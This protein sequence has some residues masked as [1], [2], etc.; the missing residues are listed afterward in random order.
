MNPTQRV[1]LLVNSM[2]LRMIFPLSLHRAR[3]RGGSQRCSRNHGWVAVSRRRAA[4]MNVAIERVPQTCSERAGA[5][6]VRL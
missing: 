4:P 3:E 5:S 1:P 6:H 2:A